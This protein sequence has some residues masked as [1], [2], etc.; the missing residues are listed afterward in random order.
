MKSTN[1]ILAIIVVLIFL[2]VVILII[3]NFLI[4]L[5]FQPKFHPTEI[6]P[7]LEKRGLSFIDSNYLTTA[8]RRKFHF[9]KS[10]E[11][12]L[13][14]FITVKSDYLITVFSKQQNEVQLFLLEINNWLFPYPKW[15]YETL[16]GKRIENR[17]E[18]NFTEVTNPEKLKKAQKS[19][20][21]EI[22]IKDKCPACNNRVSPENK[23]CSDCGLTLNI[24]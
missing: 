10:E 18:L 3:R 1:I 23:V 17:R 20:K 21:N 9:K 19:Y 13:E 12:I 22:I 24:F 15:I 11:S 7:Y 6:F 14:K 8:K 16:V 5:L 4:P 2:S